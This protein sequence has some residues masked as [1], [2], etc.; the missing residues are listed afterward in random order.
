MKKVLVSVWNDFWGCHLCEG[1]VRAGFDVT[2]HHTGGMKAR[3]SQDMRNWPAAFL[4]HAAFKGWLNQSLAFALSRRIV[5]AKAAHLCKSYDA[6]WGWSGCSLRA[7][8]LAKERGI[9]A[10]LER[11]S[12][13]C[14]LQREVVHAQF[15]RF[16]AAHLY[17]YPHSQI[18]YEKAEYET[19]S[20]ICVPSQFVAA[21]FYQKGFTQDEVSINPYGVDVNFWSQSKPN[22]ERPSPFTFLYVASIGLRKGVADLL[23]AWKLANL[24]NARLV[25]IGGVSAE[26]IPLLKCLPPNVEIRGFTPHEEIRALMSKSHAYI[27]PSFEEGLARSVLE[28]AAAGLPPI[29]TKETGATDILKDG[30]DCW[31]IPSGQ[32]DALSIALKEVAVNHEEAR[33]RGENA[34]LAVKQFTWVAYGQRAAHQ[35]HTILQIQDCNIH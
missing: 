33:R 16:G 9:P 17:H 25:F 29:I 27:L 18:V 24:H 34:S 1:L 15:Q 10:L 13:H 30:C 6:F 3:G 8:R 26:A 32:P 11:G 22:F 12:T 7:L 5:D 2:Y 14:E 35:L 31:V 28:A 19:A 4:N 21:T 20:R 23:E